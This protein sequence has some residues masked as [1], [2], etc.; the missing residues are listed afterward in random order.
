MLQIMLSSYASTPK[1]RILVKQ[2]RIGPKIM[3]DVLITKEEVDP[4][5]R[6]TNAGLKTEG[7][8]INKGLALIPTGDLSN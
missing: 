6:F 3:N 1:W 8:M 5:K 4:Q 7:S 2:R